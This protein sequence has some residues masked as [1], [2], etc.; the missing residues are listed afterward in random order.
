MAVLRFI[1]GDATGLVYPLRHQS[2]LLG[3]NSECDIVLNSVSVSRHHARIFYQNGAY[4]IEDMGSRNGTM[5]NSSPV[6]QPSE[7]K[8]RD[9]ICICDVLLLFLA[10]GHEN[11]RSGYEDFQAKIEDTGEDE[12]SSVLMTYNMLGE[13]VAKASAEAKLRA[14]VA[15]GKNLGE[16]GR[17]EDVLLRILDSLFDIFPQA[18]RGV[19]VLRDVKTG[20]LDAKAL[21]QRDPKRLDVRLSRT[22]LQ[23]AIGTRQAILSAD[24]VHDERFSTSD[25]VS[26]S[27]IRSVMCVP[28]LGQN[29]E[30]LGVTQLDASTV[31]KQFDAADLEI[32]ASVSG[33]VAI[34][35][36]NAQLMEAA[37]A[38][39]SHQREM[40]VAHRVQRGLLPAGR[41]ECAEYE[42]FDH[43]APA[44]QLGGDYYDYVSLASGHLAI[45]LADVAGKG[46]SA[47]L[48]MAK[49]SADMKY[50][51]A[52]YS[53]PVDV[54]SDLNNH[55]CDVRWDD[56]FVTMVV[57]ILDQATHRLTLVNAG[58][59]LPVLCHADGTI[60]LV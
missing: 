56:S 42:F 6:T 3:R 28:R 1:R 22:I 20:T 39:A 19:I 38:D 5:V 44:R 25:S 36:Q 41:P 23:N 52:M 17:L 58:H 32:L 12:H 51:L 47:A 33:L 48:V 50:L 14:M 34:A 4:L 27:P 11:D 43:Y 49:L 21:K 15:I 37:L 53:D 10:D 18:E 24:V 2:Y 46:V 35:I 45:V 29:Q 8:H 13:P 9:R 30:V 7:L 55:F 16:P 59:L 60:R 26:I 40:E 54:V 57:A 31:A